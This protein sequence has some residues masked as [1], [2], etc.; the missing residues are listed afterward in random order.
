MAKISKEKW[1]VW[2]NVFDE[3]TFRTLF[4]LASQGH[5]EELK[6][7]VSIG[8]ESNIF[9]AKKSKE[10]IIIKIYR[11]ETCDFNKMYDYS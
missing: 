2:G 9:S 8:K 10:N 4:K 11:L 5:F 6:S 1:K 7:P 3:F